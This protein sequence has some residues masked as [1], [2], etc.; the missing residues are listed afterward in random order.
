MIRRARLIPLVFALVLA[1]CSSSNDQTPEQ[2]TAQFHVE[3]AQRLYDGHHYRRSLQ[4]FNKA[5]ALDT[6]NQAALL[7]RAWCLLFLAE[8]RAR[9]GD[10]Q[11][12]DTL[13]ETELAFA[14]IVELDYGANQFKI[15]LGLG[16]VHVIY[17]DLYAARADLLEGRSVAR[18]S[19]ET[20]DIAWH[21]TIKER[22]TEYSKARG[23]F[24]AVLAQKDNAGARD[25][26]TAL[27]HL[28]RIA[29]IKRDYA[30][31]LVYA[32]RYLSQVEQSK[33]LWVESSVRFPRD[34]G[35]WEAKLAGAVT[36]EIE[37]RDLI[38]DI[39]YKLGRLELAEKELTQLIFLSPE[40]TDSYL[41]RGI[42]RDELGRKEEALEDYR[43]FMVRAARLD[44]EATD[45]RVLKA[46]E[47]IIELEKELDLPSTILDG[48]EKEE[49]RR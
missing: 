14:D 23:Y 35:I 17:G 22:N 48:R 1:A 28:A 49:A 30:E 11:A 20:Q 31:S 33:N 6:E 13:A 12:D 7:G 47:R 2:H 24:K 9:S 44:L 45:K 29:V 32:E 3:N 19:S 8:Q 39:L 36:K 18:T 41:N 40:R 16:K 25:N 4:Q 37:V 38:A 46:T 27:I 21:A 26:L 34:K 15:T 43:S 42:V 5:L 10:R